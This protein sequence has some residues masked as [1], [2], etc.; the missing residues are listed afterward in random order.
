MSLQN[1][2]QKGHS[3]R[4]QKLFGPIQKTFE[5][6]NVTH[7]PTAGKIT[8][9]VKNIKNVTQNFYFVDKNSETNTVSQP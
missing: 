5:K 6:V 1:K 8:K 3:D 7:M 2:S 9:S 4:A